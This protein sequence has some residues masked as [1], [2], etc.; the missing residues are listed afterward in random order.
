MSGN[1]ASTA[2]PTDGGTAR[3]FVGRRHLR[4]CPGGNPAVGGAA[5]RWRT[6]RRNQDA[7]DRVAA[8]ARAGRSVGQHPCRRS[9]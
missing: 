8:D 6:G 4:R 2:K 7:L 5:Q 9:C 3:E 1:I